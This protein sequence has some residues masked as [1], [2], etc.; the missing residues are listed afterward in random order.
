MRPL[1]RT[2]RRVE[3]DIGAVFARVE[4]FDGGGFV[5]PFDEVFLQEDGVAPD[6]GDDGVDVGVGGLDGGFGGQVAGEDVDALGL[7]GGD[8]GEFGGDGVGRG[9]DRDAREVRAGEDELVRYWLADRA[10]CADDEYG[11]FG[12][13]CGRRWG[14]V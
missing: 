4:G 7:Q 3:L 1:A 6:A 9:E 5:G 10:C 2:G 13:H 14:R 12:G 11:G 8:V